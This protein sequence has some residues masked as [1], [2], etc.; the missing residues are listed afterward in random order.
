MQSNHHNDIQLTFDE[1]LCRAPAWMESTK[2]SRMAGAINTQTS[3][4]RYGIDGTRTSIR[5]ARPSITN[6]RGQILGKDGAEENA[7][8][9][10]KRGR[11][12]EA[13]GQEG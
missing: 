11:L 13:V 6:T 12:H 4:A 9:H 1:N 3:E 7:P 8:H 2:E 10:Q 5:L